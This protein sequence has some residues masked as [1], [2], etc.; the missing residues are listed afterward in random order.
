M[1]N[2]YLIG[3]VISGSALAAPAAAATFVGDNIQ[4]Y[5]N[6]VSCGSSTVSGGVEFNRGSSTYNFS[7]AGL[8]VL[9][10]LPVRNAFVNPLVYSFEN[11]NQKF[12]SFSNLSITGF[13]NF[14]PNRVS[15]N[16]GRIS[17]DLS[18]IDSNGQIS[19]NLSSVPEPST[20]IMMMLGFGVIGATMRSARRRQKVSIRYA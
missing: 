17:I 19:M 8:T 20:W 2:R 14:S 5:R 7:G 6:G 4:C 1:K 15:L 3:L 12:L 10:A 16:N 9:T 18:G 13:S 11:T